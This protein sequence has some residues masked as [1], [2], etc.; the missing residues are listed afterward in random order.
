MYI[1]LALNIPLAVLPHGGHFFVLE[2]F[3]LSYFCCCCSFVVLGLN[4]GPC[5]W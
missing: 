4:S 2:V 5:T 1:S 3:L